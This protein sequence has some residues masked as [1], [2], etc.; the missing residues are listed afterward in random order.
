MEDKNTNYVLKICVR[1]T[2]FDIEGYV[3]KSIPFLKILFEQKRD[4]IIELNSISPCFL[5]HLIT[6]TINKKKVT[7]LKKILEEE[8][9]QDD[10]IIFL[11]YLGMHD[12]LDKMY[13]TIPTFN[14]KIIIV[15]CGADT[16]K[17]PDGLILNRTDVDNKKYIKI[18]NEIILEE[19][20]N[21]I[22]VIR[23]NIVYDSHI[24]RQNIM[25]FKQYIA[26]QN[27]LKHMNT[28]YVDMDTYYKMEDK[29]KRI[30]LLN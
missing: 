22:C 19:T 24:G 8:F 21:S 20:D 9:D 17:D 5:T 4:D 2:S 18:L 12:M 10:I 25:D 11:K 14:G 15:S 27:L 16:W 26:K 13:N 1:G 3:A 29:F 7:C 6:H 30:G 23:Q 28:F